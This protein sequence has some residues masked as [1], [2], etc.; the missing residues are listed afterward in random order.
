MRLQLRTYSFDGA[1]V[2][3]TSAYA[4]IMMAVLRF[5]SSRNSI[6]YFECRHG[7]CPTLLHPETSQLLLTS[8]EGFSQPPQILDASMFGCTTFGSLLRFGN[9]I[10]VS[11]LRSH[12][13][14]HNEDPGFP[15]DAGFRARARRRRTRDWQK[16]IDGKVISTF[17]QPRRLEK[18]YE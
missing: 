9:G 11:R 15:R 12:G 8:V 14:Q 1:E 18:S 6:Y 17:E 3:S 10:R 5:R 7:V 13:F 16:G 2:W 4:P